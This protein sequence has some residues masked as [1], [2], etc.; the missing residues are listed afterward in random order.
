M[1]SAQLLLIVSWCEILVLIQAKDYIFQG[2]TQR[3]PLSPDF[4]FLFKKKSLEDEVHQI[5]T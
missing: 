2:N 3:K 4:I 1:W 5:I